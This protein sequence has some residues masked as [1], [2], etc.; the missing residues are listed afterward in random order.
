[1]GWSFGAIGAKK[2]PCARL[3]SAALVVNH[4]INAKHHLAADFWLGSVLYV[5]K[6]LFCNVLR[7]W[8]LVAVA[9]A[10]VEID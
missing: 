2:R 5:H 8:L 9:F 3:Y 1:M 4:C 6:L 7:C 10:P